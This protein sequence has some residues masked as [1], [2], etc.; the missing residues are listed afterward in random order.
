MEN[1]KGRTK[2]TSEHKLSVDEAAKL[3]GVSPQYVRIALQRGIFPFGCA[4]RMSGKNYSYVI[5]K[6]KFT[7]FTGIKV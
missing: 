4:I 2:V 6:E 3:M 5:F 1:R 7:E